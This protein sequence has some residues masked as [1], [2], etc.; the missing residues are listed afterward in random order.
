MKSFRILISSILTAVLAMY[1]WS[2]GPGR[3]RG[4]D[5]V[6]ASPQASRDAPSPTTAPAPAAYECRWT[7]E[8]I[9]LNGRAD[10]PAWKNAQVISNFRVPRPDGAWRKPLMATR[11]KLLWDRNYLYYYA[12]MDDAD[13]YATI[14]EH[15]GKVWTNDAFEMFLK[16]D[17]T[18]PG[19]YEFEV[20]PA[21]TT[22]ELYFP[23][24]DAGGYDKFKDLTHI[25]MKTAVQLHGTLNQ[26]LDT[27]KGWSVEG[28]I[29][30]S[31][32]LNTGGRPDAGDLWKFALCRV[33]YSSK[34]KSTE[35]S[36]NAPLTKVNFHRYEDYSTV[37]FVGPDRTTSNRPYGIDHRVPL[38]T[39]RVVGYPEPP[40]PYTVV[41]AFPKLKIFQPLYILEEPGTNNF[42][43]LQHLGVWAGPGRLLRFKN[44]PQVDHA[45]TVLDVDRI[46][47][48]MAL[49]PDF[50]H[51]GYIYLMS[52][53]PVEAQ[54]KQDRISRY[55]IDRRTGKIDPATELVYL[56]WDSNGHNGGDLA[57]GPDGYLYHAAGDGT[58]GGDV[59]LRGQD[60]THLTSAMIRIDVH[61]PSGGKPY[62][63]PS[64]NPFID[65]SGARPE[66]WAYG[67]RNPWRL[68]FDGKTGQLWVG[69]NGQDAWE[70]IYIAHRGENYGWSVYEGSHPFNLHHKQG[71]T[72]ITWPTVEHPHSEMRSLTGGVVY[73]G[74]K[75]PELNGA[76]IYGDWST[77]RIWGVKAPGDKVT[78]HREL[79]R[80]PM[81]IVG[82]RETSGGD[83]LVVDQGSGIYKLTVAPKVA[84]T[85]PFP[86][87]LSDTGLFVSTRDNV[88]QPGLI[89]YDVNAPL[90]SDGA[91]KERFIA[92]PEGGTIDVTPAHGWNFPEATVL[93]KTFSLATDPAN[94]TAARRIETR[95][96]TKQGGQWAGYSYIW[97][98]AQ[99]D[100][101]LVGAAGFDQKYIVHDSA[102]PGGTRSQRW[103]FPSR[104]ECMTCHTRASNFV[105]GPSILQ[106]NKDHDYHGVVDNQLRTL[107]HLGVI[108]A[109]YIDFARDRLHQELLDAG[110]TD[111]QANLLMSSMTD[112]R[113]QHE[114]KPES[115]LAFDP[116]QMPHLVDPYDRHQS[117]DQ[118]ARS[119]LHANCA[120]CH[121]N[122]GGGN[123]LLNVEYGVP[124]DKMRIIDVPPEHD[125]FGIENA[126]IVAS[127]NA[128]A[129]VLYHRVNIRGQGQMPPLASYE[130]DAGA[131][132]LLHEWIEQMKPASADA[133]YIHH[134]Q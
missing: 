23:A 128:G 76:F 85:P 96:L 63:I 8:L 75:L 28:R 10:E 64:D 44:D 88:P 89:P 95:L 93:V 33:D 111:D 50:I 52:N 39:S 110:K 54:V 127:G 119:Y 79:A 126:K 42:L 43:L 35:L 101:N 30:W 113:D 67:F 94:R 81:Q 47:Y 92:L 116:A 65:T 106:M 91:T 68:A 56:E 45:E 69:Q 103:H 132:K 129:S 104:A 57:F 21:N 122:D 133:T 5:V 37:K 66:V 130:V 26:P 3:P 41:K 4:S 84:P 121:V 20:S 9:T 134:H 86:R 38:T 112:T 49:D 72:P 83:L 120:I 34:N 24:R 6:A 17:D 97:N 124:V 7:D 107:E 115:I 77:G 109:S 58:S 19:Y 118:R 48:G 53:G 25:E 90:W 40:P 74:T 18:K 60:I 12:E 125:S 117:V 123:S 2:C 16:P 131:V 32:M 36:S 27:D 98:D 82:F 105:L 13:L 80:T 62:S 1:V 108:R 14:T 102:A 61:H 22:L 11:A 31:N 100:A 70:Q 87:K 59:N 71:P 29:R 51:N 46:A 99:T 73:Y 114:P 15:Q 78:W 55:T